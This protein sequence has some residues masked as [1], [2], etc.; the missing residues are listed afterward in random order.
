VLDGV[1]G[2]TFSLGVPGGVNGFT[3]ASMRQVPE[4]N[5]V[6]AS[7]TRTLAG[8]QGLLAFNLDQQTVSVLSVPDGYVTVS[9]LDDAG[10]PCCIATHKIVARAF[11]AGGTA[12][13]MY[14]LTTN[15]VVLVPN[16]DGVVSIGALPRAAAGGGQ[17]QVP[18]GQGQG[19]QL[20]GAGG[21]GAAV[22][23]APLVSAN[24]NAN[25]VSGVAFSADGKQAGIVV[26]RI[27]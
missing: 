3:D 11:K 27:P 17:G 16:P 15:D 6:L 22:A 4:I 7:A 19:G 2:S 26:V 24:F 25:T 12:I 9:T 8:D 21:A 5:S 18:P 20:P 14:N 13:V 1:N 10:T 23:V